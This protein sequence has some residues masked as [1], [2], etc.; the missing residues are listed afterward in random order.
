MAAVKDLNFH[1]RP[2]E[3]FGISGPNG[4]GKTTLFDIVS[5]LNPA[6]E[7][8]VLFDG[9]RITRSSPQKICR[10]GLARVFQSNACFD[11]L[12]VRENV[13]VGAV[14]GP[15]PALPLRVDTATHAWVEETMTQAGLAGK[16]EEP[17]RNLPVLD[18]K[19]LMFASA[20]ASRPKMLLLDEPV[21][22]LN[23]HEID[24]ITA[25]VR[26]TAARGV[27]IVLIEH[28]MRFMVMLAT[29]IM[30]MQ[31]GEKIFEG[32]PLELPRDPTVAS[33]YLGEA[34][35]RGLAEFL[36]HRQ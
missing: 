1:V 12:T 10:R 5:G 29:R 14:Y 27:T 8:E 15:G 24:E 36:D 35:A 20:L 3:I 31:H 18:R 16:A 28:V 32:T 9:Q 22:G 19:R 11:S 23:L 7:G 21:G 13:T 34:A 4:A 25:L 26:D 2:G 30:V 6:D 33:V 17:A